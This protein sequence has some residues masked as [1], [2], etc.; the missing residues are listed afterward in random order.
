MNRFLKLIVLACLLASLSTL[1]SYAASTTITFGNLQGPDNSPFSAYVESGFTVAALAGNFYKAT[2]HANNFGDPEPDV[3]T[4]TSGTISVTN[5]GLFSFTS[6]D[7]GFYDPGTIIY[8]VTG[9]LNGATIF[10]QN[11]SLTDSHART[12]ET[13]SSTSAAH[14][15]MLKIQIISNT[16]G[17]ANIDNISFNTAV[18]PEPSSL[19][20]LGSGAL[21]LAG[22][23]KRRLA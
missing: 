5:G 10:T 17:G 20:L 21:S 9:L 14:I 15:N 1:S 13:L 12:F 22:L 18:T 19:V 4:D 7:L 2:G 6:V 3:Y 23:I 8:S 16:T 11:G